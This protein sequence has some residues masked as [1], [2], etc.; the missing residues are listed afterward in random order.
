[1]DEAS[2]AYNR[3]VR[4]SPAA[5]SGSKDDAVHHCSYKALLIT[6]K[7]LAN[8]RCGLL[9]LEMQHW[10]WE[11]K[12]KVTMAA[13]EPVTHGA[14]YPALYLQFAVWDDSSIN[15][16][17]SSMRHALLRAPCCFPRLFL[18]SRFLKSLSTLGG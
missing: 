12:E 15:Y 2:M 13:M 3:A 17:I 11:V 16:G 10:S 5:P 7:R 8:C 18:S 1:M 6:V 14:K 9:F 4:S